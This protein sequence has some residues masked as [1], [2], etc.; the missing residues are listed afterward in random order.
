[1]KEV[2]FFQN[3]NIEY[4]DYLQTIEDKMKTVKIG[5]IYTT[6][7]KGVE[8]LGSIDEERKKLLIDTSIEIDKNLTTPHSKKENRERKLIAM[9]AVANLIGNHYDGI[10]HLNKK[11][12]AV[13]GDYMI[14]YDDDEIDSFLHVVANKELLDAVIKKTKDSGYQYEILTTVGHKCPKECYDKENVL[15]IN[16]FQKQMIGIIET[17]TLSEIMDM[18]IP[19]EQMA[20]ELKNSGIYF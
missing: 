9:M 2:Y 1:M 18:Q 12:L 15:E 13:L 6:F 10:S 3:K 17:S 8:T 7:P 16:N 4:S 20:N 14:C 19:G 5:G 11:Q